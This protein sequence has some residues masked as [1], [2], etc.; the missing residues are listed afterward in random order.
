MFLRAGALHPDSM[1]HQEKSRLEKQQAENAK[2]IE[3]LQAGITDL[4]IK[5]PP[6]VP[7]QYIVETIEGPIKEMM[8]SKIRP[9]IEEFQ[10]EMDGILHTRNEDYQSLWTKIGITQKMVTAIANQVNREQAGLVS[11]VNVEASTASS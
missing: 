8:S 3:S 10:R 5:P 1:A 9:L 7:Q 11:P 2:M 6:T 4:K